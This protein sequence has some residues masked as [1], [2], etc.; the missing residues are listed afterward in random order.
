[1]KL[2]IAIT[3]DPEL[4]IPPGLYGGIERIVDMLVQGLTVQGHDV[5]LFAHPDSKVPCRLIAWKGSKSTGLIDTIK[6]TGLLAQSVMKEKYD[7][8]HSF[9]RLA[10]LTPI[11]PLR[12]VKMMSYQ[13]EPSLVQISKATRLSKNGSLLFTGCSNYITDQIKPVAKAMTI[14]NGVPIEKY[15]FKKS[16]EPDAPLVFLGRI[17]FIKGTHVAIEVARKT[18]RR[19]IIAGN[20]PT[21]AK[22]YFEKNVKPHLHGAVSY[23]GPVNDAQKNDLLGQAAAFLM[24]IQW[25]EPFGIV[26]TEAM[27]CGTPVIGLPYGAVPEIVEDGITGFVC[28]D[29][30]DMIRKIERLDMID[31]NKVRSVAEERFSDRVIVAQYLSAYTSLVQQKNVPLS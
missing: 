7:I 1:M 14:Y 5:T 12:T 28:R 29:A 10:Y 24:P 23:I 11:L 18:G 30:E 17:E 27:A 26:M 25:N 4:P 3:A 31:R 15:T 16:V 13:R 21:G 8:V 9:G 20:I 6:N 19:L 22:D 2:K